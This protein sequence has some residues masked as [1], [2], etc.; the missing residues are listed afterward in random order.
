MSALRL[1]QLKGQILPENKITTMAGSPSPLTTHVL[2]T[3][4]GVPGSNMTLRL[5]Q[6]DPS[7]NVWKLIT[8]GATNVDGR[9]PGLITK[10]QFKPD[11]FY[12][13]QRRSKVS[14]PPACESFLLQYVQGEL[15][16][17]NWKP[18]E[19]SS[20]KYCLTRKKSGT[21]PPSTVLSGE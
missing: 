14:C 13:N 10:E 6:Q 8:A 3:A 4:M 7:T 20:S 17:K 1:Q 9:C 18:P 12:H 15:E 19:Y 16:T 11:C 21:T 2:N 5:Y